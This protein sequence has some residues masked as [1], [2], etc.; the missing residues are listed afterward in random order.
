MLAPTLRLR[1]AAIPLSPAQ[2][3]FVRGV[4]TRKEDVLKYL[5]K[6][7]L[8]SDAS[9]DNFDP[10]VQLNARFLSSGEEAAFGNTLTPVDAQGKPSIE[11][12]S[13]PQEDG[14]PSSI[15]GKTGYIVM[16]DLDAPSRDNPE[17]SEF[18]HWIAQV[19]L[20][21]TKEGGEIV[22][23]AKEGTFKE[24]TEYAGPAPPEKSGPHRYLLLL[25]Q[26]GEG[27]KGVSG[28]SKDD[29]KKW[30]DSE[31][32]TGVAKWAKDN[33]LT[34]IGANFFFSEYKK[35]QTVDDIHD[36]KRGL[37]KSGAGYGG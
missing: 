26:G 30:G 37:G 19:Q 28:P 12:L 4:A 14:I 20:P 15:Q 1:G 34:P 22:H 21:T 36:D 31:Q 33:G 2:Q 32:R 27:N 29:R 11:I 8:I 9:L 23:N 13:F 25:L 10:K 24:I 3:R 5:T 7:E 6:N 16:T 17:W 18:C 35:E